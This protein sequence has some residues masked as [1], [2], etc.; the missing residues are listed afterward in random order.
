MLLMTTYPPSDISRDKNILLVLM[1]LGYHTFY[2]TAHQ[3]TFNTIQWPVSTHSKLISD[4]MP[5]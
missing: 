4:T 1:L 5:L 2:S 3:A